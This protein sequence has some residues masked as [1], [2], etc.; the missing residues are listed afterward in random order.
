MS[1]NKRSNTSMFFGG[2]S[3]KQHTNTYPQCVLNMD[4]PEDV[5]KAMSVKLCA[6]RHERPTIKYV[7]PLGFRGSVTLHSSETPLPVNYITPNQSSIIVRLD[8]S[9]PAYKVFMSIEEKVQGIVPERV[10]GLITPGVDGLGPTM[11]LKDTQYTVWKNE[12]G[13]FIDY[14]PLVHVCVLPHERAP[15]WRLPLYEV[16]AA[17]RARA[18]PTGM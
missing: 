17:V 11:K 18:P 5:D 16:D 4:K 3:K 7:S 14:Y 15:R 9:T 8:E 1:Y 12:E 6:G 13:G 2:P 10:D